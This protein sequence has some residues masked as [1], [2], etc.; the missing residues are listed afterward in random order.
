MS[1]YGN[2]IITTIANIHSQPPII[3]Q[4]TEKVPSPTSLCRLPEGIWCHFK[5]LGQS[6][7]NGVDVWWPRSFEGGVEKSMGFGRTCTRVTCQAQGWSNG[8]HATAIVA[9]AF[10]WF[11][12]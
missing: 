6:L 4:G 1:T 12:Y 11:F 8:H 5:D 3:L 9:S 10:L 7:R 2:T